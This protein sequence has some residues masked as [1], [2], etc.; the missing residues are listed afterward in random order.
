MLLKTLEIQM[1]SHTPGPWAIN[2]NGTIG[3]IKSLAEH[4]QGMTPT[5]ARFD[6]N[7]IAQTIA[8]HEAIANANLM[9]ASPDLLTACKA[10]MAAMEKELE[11]SGEILWLDSPFVLPGVHE[12]AIERLRNV[13]DQAEGRVVE[14]IEG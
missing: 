6:G 8:E 10:V 4:P 14:E 12:S 2:Y 7:L 11:E 13:I 1:V 5:V 9:A 3:H